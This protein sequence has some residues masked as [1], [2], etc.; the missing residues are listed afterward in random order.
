MQDECLQKAMVVGCGRD[1]VEE[2][3]AV[4][5]KISGSSKLKYTRGTRI[6]TYRSVHE[7]LL[8]ALLNHII[9]RLASV[10]GLL[11]TNCALTCDESKGGS[12][13]LYKLTP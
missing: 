3:G 12:R 13:L 4:E 6:R 8:A 2:A 11:D 1:Q 5:E 10:R 7:G 9:G